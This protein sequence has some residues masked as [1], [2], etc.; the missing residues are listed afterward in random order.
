MI[1]A[2]FAV[3]AGFFW[4]GSALEMKEF[5]AA[6]SGTEQRGFCDGYISAIRSDHFLARAE[7]RECPYQ[8]TESPDQVVVFLEYAASKKDSV[9][10]IMRAD[11]AIRV[12]F[13][14]KYPCG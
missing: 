8:G 5:C 2:I 9:L 3:L 11:M 13:A 1:G 14:R 12:A 4:D 6:P 7:P 10:A